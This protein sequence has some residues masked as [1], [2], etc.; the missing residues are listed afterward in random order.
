M[1][2][3]VWNLNQLSEELRVA[4]GLED[5]P[6]IRRVS[7]A[8]PE[9]LAYRNLVAP[10]E[11]ED[12]PW[13]AAQQATI[14]ATLEAHVADPLWGERQDD[15]IIRLILTDAGADAYLA[16]NPP[17]QAQ[18]VAVIKD[19]IRAVRALARIERRERQ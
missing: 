3:K 7:D 15:R 11:Y 14:R 6:G 1:A 10:D 13:T 16:A 2:S 8:L 19:L 17:T 4:L 12:V 18:S 9:V 5:A